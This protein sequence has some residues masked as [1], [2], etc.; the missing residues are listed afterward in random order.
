MESGLRFEDREDERRRIKANKKKLKGGSISV[1]VWT[2]LS[3]NPEAVSSA[4]TKQ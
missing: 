2:K 3:I 1:G 4:D